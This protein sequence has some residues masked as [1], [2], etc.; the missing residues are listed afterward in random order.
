[1]EILPHTLGCFVCGTHNPQG[2]KL[3]L[4]SDSQVVESRFQFRNEHCGFRGTV[5]GGLVATV[6]DEA[7]AW[8][9]GVHA[10]RFSYCAELNTRFLAPAAPGVDL[11]LRAELVE[12]KRGRLFLTRS[13]LRDAQGVVLAEATG[14][15]LP[16][17]AARHAEMLADFAENP[18]QWVDL[19]AGTS[20]PLHPTPMPPV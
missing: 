10:R 9:I 4:L 16:I 5:H 1:M 8:V 3:D 13:E 19:G 17:P 15:Y 18:G 14:K 6:L 7:M 11:H 2:L 20:S 12:N